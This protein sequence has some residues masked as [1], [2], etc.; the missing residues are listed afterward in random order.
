MHSLIEDI[1]RSLPS[2]G[3]G[4]KNKD[5]KKKWWDTFVAIIDFVYLDKPKTDA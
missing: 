4:F 5:E 1:I 2:Q 3:D